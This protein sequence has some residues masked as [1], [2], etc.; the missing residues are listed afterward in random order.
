MNG[1]SALE[2]YKEQKAEFINKYQLLIDEKNLRETIE[3]AVENI[4]ENLKID[5]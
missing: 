1:K 3:N 5:L 2:N 4:L